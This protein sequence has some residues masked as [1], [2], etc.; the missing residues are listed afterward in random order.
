M[1]DLF[2]PFYGY[3]FEQ[4]VEDVNGIYAKGAWRE[5]K[6]AKRAAELSQKESMLTGGYLGGILRLLQLLFENDPD[7][8]FVDSVRFDILRDPLAQCFELT[9]LFPSA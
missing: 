6:Q 4:I 3:F 1:G 5:K 7:E 8:Q 9:R 2:V